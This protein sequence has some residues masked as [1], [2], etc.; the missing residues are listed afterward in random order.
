VR[1]ARALKADN[2]PREHKNQGVMVW[3]CWMLSRGFGQPP[4][5]VAKSPTASTP[6]QRQGKQRWIHLGRSAVGQIH[7]P[8]GGRGET[9]QW[10]PWGTRLLGLARSISTEFFTVGHTHNLVDQRFACVGKILSQSPVLQAPSDFLSAIENQ[11]APTS[12]RDLHVEM[13][14]G[15]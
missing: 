1:P 2:T 4:N 10:N 6:A 13:L 9:R 15:I 7:L 8:R 14:T 12:G 3:S 5:L 11:L